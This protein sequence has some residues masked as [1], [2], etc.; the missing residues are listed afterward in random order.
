MKRFSIKVKKNA[1]KNE[2]DL[3]ERWKLGT[4]TTPIWCF[5]LQNK[6]FPIMIYVADMAILMSNFDNFDNDQIS[7]KFAQRWYFVFYFHC[8]KYFILGSLDVAENSKWNLFMDH[9]ISGC[10]FVRYGLWEYAMELNLELN[11][12]FH[13]TEAIW[14]GCPK[15]NTREHSRRL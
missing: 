11:F 14:L 7:W 10:H 9:P 13:E 4:W 1:R 12:F 6:I 2:D 5:L 8:K 3:A 15:S